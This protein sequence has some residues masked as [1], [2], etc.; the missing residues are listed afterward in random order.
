MRT[1]CHL[2]IAQT[3]LTYYQEKKKLQCI[4]NTQQLTFTVPASATSSIDSYCETHRTSMW[5]TDN[6]ISDRA[7]T[8]TGSDMTIPLAA[9]SPLKGNCT[10]VFHDFVSSDKYC[11]FK[12]IA[13]LVDFSVGKADSIRKCYQG[14]NVPSYEGSFVSKFVRGAS[15]MIFSKTRRVICMKIC[16]KTSL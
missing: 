13:Q 10:K 1:L 9:F 15:Q 5:R 4:N 3:L 6:I 11:D 16:M 14:T 8:Q 2:R 12:T 7:W